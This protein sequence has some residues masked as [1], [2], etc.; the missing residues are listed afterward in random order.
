MTGRATEA[1]LDA[2][3]ARFSAHLDALEKSQTSLYA[4]IA[5]QLD[6]LESRL[7]TFPW[8]VGVAIVIAYL[9]SRYG[10]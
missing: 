3:D 9:I 4:T 1:R 2:M 5:A 6:A 7:K 8:V 10:P